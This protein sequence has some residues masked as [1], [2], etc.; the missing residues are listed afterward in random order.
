VR[1]DLVFFASLNDL[2]VLCRSLFPEKLA[3]N[4]LGGQLNPDED[5]L[6]TTCHVAHDSYLKISSKKT[7]SRIEMTAQFRGLH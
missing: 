4:V 1:N 5:L 7:R 2:C 3:L 6:I